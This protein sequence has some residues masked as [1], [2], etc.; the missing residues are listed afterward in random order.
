MC[1]VGITGSLG[2]GKTTVARLLQQRGA[3]V[4]DADRQAHA[5]LLPKGKC[6]QKVVRVFGQGIVSRGYIDRRKLAD[7]VFRQPG[8]LKKLCDITHPVIAQQIKAEVSRYRQKRTHRLL[9]LDVPLL[10]EVGLERICDYVVVV[11]S[12]VKTQIARLQKRNHFTQSEIVRRIKAQ[13]P[14]AVKV[15]RADFVIHNQGSLEKTRK[16]VEE[17]CRELKKKKM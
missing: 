11:R 7:I 4:I 15:A 2:S 8:A 10:F 12:S 6:F 14:I 3:K 9:V 1:I 5:L 16:Q 13:M 17:L